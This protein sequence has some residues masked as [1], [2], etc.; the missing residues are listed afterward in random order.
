VLDLFTLIDQTL[1][2]ELT[3][4]HSVADWLQL[5]QHDGFGEFVMGQ[6]EQLQFLQGHHAASNGL[7]APLE[8]L[9]LET[10]GWL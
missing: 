2:S 5:A 1:R 9:R 3:E 10:S 6:S 7:H 4:V 8:I